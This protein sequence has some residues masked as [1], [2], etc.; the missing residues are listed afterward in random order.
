VPAAD[1][2]PTPAVSTAE[3][4]ILC[5]SRYSFAFLMPVAARLHQQQPAFCWGLLRAQKRVPG[6]QAVQ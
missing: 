6:G 3:A 4:C 1:A 5:G 2:P